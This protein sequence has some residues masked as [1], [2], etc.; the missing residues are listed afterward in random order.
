MSRNRGGTSNSRRPHG[1][2][3]Y[4]G[5][6]VR[7]L[8][9]EAWS[10]SLAPIE[11]LA[12]SGA[13]HAAD[14]LLLAATLALGAHQAVTFGALAADSLP[15]IPGSSVPPANSATGTAANSPTTATAAT[16]AAAAAA[17]A[18]A[19][20][21][22]TQAT[23][24]T[25]G[26]QQS[27]SSSSFSSSYYSG[28]GN[29]P[30]LGELVAGV[31]SSPDTINSA[32]AT[33]YPAPP[34]LVALA[35][36]L[37]SA[38][39][40]RTPGPTSTFEAI[41]L[42]GRCQA[43][44]GQWESAV[45]TLAE[46][47]SSLDVLSL[48]GAET[49]S[50]LEEAT[51]ASQA[52]A[53]CG[54]ALEQCPGKGRKIEALTY[55][56][57]SG[58]LAASRVFAR[59][60]I[61][62]GKGSNSSSYNQHRPRKGRVSGQAER[63]CEYALQRQVFL[64]LEGDN[65]P[66][67]VDL[68]RHILQLDTSPTLRLHIARMLRMVLMRQPSAF[69]VH[70]QSESPTT[71]TLLHGGGDAT[72]P[73][74]TT[75]STVTTKRKT[76]KTSSSSTSAAAAGNE[77]KM[78]SANSTVVNATA[79]EASP[80]TATTKGTHTR[81]S[82]SS[83]SSSSSSHYNYDNPARAPNANANTLFVPESAAEECVLLA[84]MEQDLL[85][86]GAVTPE[87]D[88]GPYAVLYA[89]LAQAVG[90]DSA[91]LGT[92]LETGLEISFGAPALWLAM[93]HT[94]HSAGQ[95]KAAIRALEQ[96]QQ[97]ASHGKKNKEDGAGAGSGSGSGQE[98]A[99][100]AGD[101]SHARAALLAARA[102][103][104]LGDT[105]SA[106]KS[107]EEAMKAYS[108]D[109]PLSACAGRLRGV[110][111]AMRA[112]T[113]SHAERAG[114]LRQAALTALH[115]AITLDAA[116][117]QAHY[118]YALALADARRI[119][120]ALAA[121]VRAHLL[122]DENLEALHLLAL[123]LSAQQR[124]S[125]ALAVAE[126][127]LVAGAE[128][129]VVATVLA[130]ATALGGPCAGLAAV[131]DFLPELTEAASIADNNGASA[132]GRGD[133]AAAAATAASR[134]ATALALDDAGVGGGGGGGGGSGGGDAASSIDGSS[135]V[136][137]PTASGAS[138][139]CSSAEVA[140]AASATLRAASGG[141][142]QVWLWLH[143]AE[144]YGETGCKKAAVACLLEAHRV[145]PARPEVECA[146]GRHKAADGRSEEAAAHYARALTADATH[147]PTLVAA[148]QL[149]RSM[150]DDATALKHLLAATA[151]APFCAQAWHTL[152]LVLQER[153][154]H[155]RSAM[156]LARAAE[157]AMV[158]PVRDFNVLSYSV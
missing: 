124:L 101:Q 37:V 25:A 97:H 12:G 143:L 56:S 153:G 89:D 30:A 47:C 15:Y 35:L 128:A 58:L 69:S 3:K 65:V 75:T 98:K 33:A 62:A 24:P 22:T 115:T 149:A 61:L 82:S 118:C 100:D 53:V 94:A 139:L 102:H 78:S 29:F 105:E 23:T 68:M 57:Q 129:S 1:P 117:S 142:I 121:A 16:P 20:T 144:F 151:R 125:E 39:R 81:A 80:S 152:G 51:A 60:T 44:A 109:N 6:A 88:S 99:E 84:L 132:I 137:A 130:L 32:T 45:E 54:M 108:T 5:E 93:A 154:E 48:S 70:E 36:R 138:S 31:I 46:A 41:A 59:E 140:A 18:I 34:P 49:L 113:A 27:S 145:A 86:S 148:G 8:S 66:D 7:L 96:Y 17:A 73:S 4:V 119:P 120:E 28:S 134:L 76:A 90:P 77:A 85:K 107:A 10:A 157:S 42:H 147:V 122:D 38:A 19:G 72:A 92:A 111:L 158:Q 13:D 123:L 63:D 91:V 52:L 50:S 40:S 131:R 95:D 126:K 106:Q 87:S 110:A 135:S 133:A 155:E 79:T 146:R 114:E 21:A 64:L 150:G 103:L 116:S 2:Q 67:A 74:S 141:G 156:C 71:A 26:A 55:F 104:R 136:Y 11:K 9:K 83:Y 127:A 43:A 14:A 112:R